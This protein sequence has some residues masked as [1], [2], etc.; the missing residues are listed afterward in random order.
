MER[1][2]QEWIEWANEKGFTKKDAK[3]AL[4]NLSGTINEIQALTAFA[5]FAG[6]EL[7][8]R[9]NKQG[10]AKGQVTKVKNENRLLNDR[11]DEVEKEYE[12]FISVVLG[13][14]SFLY[15]WA[16]PQG[17]KPDEE[18]EELLDSENHNKPHKAA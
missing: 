15:G 16:V 13:K 17:W 9:Q 12:G 18:I 10:A 14:L 6:S 3:R 8:D 1:T 11:L 5:K 2:K 7:R 4:A